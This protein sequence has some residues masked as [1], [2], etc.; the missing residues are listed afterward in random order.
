[1][2]A[3]VLTILDAFAVERPELTLSEIS[4]RTGLPL[5]TVHRLVG[6]LVRWGALVRRDDRAYEI[7]PGLLRVAALA[8]WNL[9]LRETAMPYLA[10][11][12]EATQQTPLRLAHIDQK[13]WPEPDGAAAAATCRDSESG[14]R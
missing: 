3:R 10:D 7:G 13:Q 14:H 12:Y 1:L 8:L 6:E 5:P 9:R 11:L 2:A 4:R